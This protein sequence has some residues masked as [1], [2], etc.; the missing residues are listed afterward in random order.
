MEILISSPSKTKWCHRQIYGC[1]GLAQATHKINLLRF[2][3]FFFQ[4]LFLSLKDQWTNM[5]GRKIHKVSHQK[6]NPISIHWLL[7]VHQDLCSDNPL[8]SLDSCEGNTG[9]LIWQLCHLVGV[10]QLTLAEPGLKL[11]S[12]HRQ[13]W[14]LST[15]WKT[16][17]KGGHPERDQHIRGMRIL[18]ALFLLPNTLLPVP[19]LL[20]YTPTHTHSLTPAQEYLDNAY[21]VPMGACLFHAYWNNGSCYNNNYKW[22]VYDNEMVICQR[23]RRRH[24]T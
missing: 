16:L 3:F 4:F 23:W 21:K 17:E 10:P 12:L 20:S 15:P 9:V 13:T 2:L 1:C 19:L 8:P 11:R 22:C 6:G 5:L 14:A 18:Q 7:F 24:R